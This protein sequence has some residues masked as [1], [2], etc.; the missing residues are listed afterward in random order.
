MWVKC[1]ACGEVHY[2]DQLDRNWWVCPNCGQH[3]RIPARK[4][5]E[6]LLDNG[7][8]IQELA[9][10]IVP[11]DPLD[12]PDYKDKIK[13]DQKKTGEK[14]AAIAGT[15]K[16]GGHKVVLFVTDFKFLGGSMG[17][18]VGEKFLRAARKAVELN[19]PLISVT[20]SGGGARMHE[21]IVS[22]MQM[23][24][25]TV[26]VIDLNNA[27]LLYINVLSDPTMA[28]V[29]ASFAALGDILIAE[30]GALLGFTGP[31][32]IQQT[33]GEELP[34]G[35]QSAEFQL[36]HGQVDMVVPRPKMRQ[37]LIRIMDITIGKP[38]A[39]A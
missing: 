24:K 9:P 13:R 23:V 35:F 10:S 25:T 11:T 39:R 16:M 12:F 6:Y 38:K 31:R 14:E 29:M 36:E 26:G 17:S 8:F 30:P 5:V 33:I 32:V 22:L 15:G 37:T 7:Q 18:V 20:A 21:G 34:E 4:F 27:G 19:H 1:K 28:G 3:M 2:R